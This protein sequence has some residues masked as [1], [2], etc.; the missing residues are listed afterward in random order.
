MSLWEQGV[1]HGEDAPA[2]VREYF[3]RPERRVLIVGGAGFD[4]RSTA[5]SS[6]IAEVTSNRRGIFIREERANPASNLVQRAEENAARLKEIVPNCQIESIEVFD[7]DDNAVVG[8]KRLIRWIAP[9]LSAVESLTDI[10]L[11]LSALSIGISFPLVRYVYETL[12][13]Q[14]SGPNVHLFVAED[15]N[16]DSGILPEHTDQPM[17]VPGFDGDAALDQQSQSTRLWIPQLVRNRHEAL[18]RIHDFVNAEET[19]PILPFPARN[20]RSGDELL[21]HFMTE[22]VDAWEVDPRNYI[23]AAEREPLDLYRTLLRLD[24]ARKRVY[25]AH[26]GSLLV[27]SPIGSR[28]L[29]LGA[30][31]AALERNFPVA[32]LESIGYALPASPSGAAPQSWPI[33]HIWL[34]GDVYA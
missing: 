13:R 8:A 31:L 33:V 1:T 29:A 32:Y 14:P 18:R 11:D 27:L 17:Y 26:G 22:I 6:S 2:F 15:P 23:Y 3:S 9:Q 25:Q 12:G 24:D 16:L 21:E 34:T 19:C 30:L 28:A 20:L 5:V 7:R 4:P 10:V